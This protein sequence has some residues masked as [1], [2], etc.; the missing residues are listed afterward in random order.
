M[1]GGPH[2]PIVHLRTY[3]ALEISRQKSAYT[4]ADLA[5]N[6]RTLN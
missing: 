5:V 3:A 1:E 6:V 4:E 2:I